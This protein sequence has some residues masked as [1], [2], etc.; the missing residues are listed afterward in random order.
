MNK[1]ILTVGF[2][3]AVV[4]GSVLLTS[5]VSAFWPFDGLFK[6]G[7]V[8]AVTTEA[9]STTS[10]SNRVAVLYKGLA[11]MNATC[12]RLYGATERVGPLETTTP[13]PFIKGKVLQTT[14]PSNESS[15]S[16]EVENPVLK[17]TGSWKE[18]PS[19]IKELAAIDTTLKSRCETIKSLLVKIKKIYKG[20][21]EATPSAKV[22][23][24]KRPGIIE[25]YRDKK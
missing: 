17:D 12:E 2:L 13:T 25:I 3:S 7:E 9:R 23:P 1:K 11:E 19:S 15:V 14:R 4:A 18:D 8:K 10:R 21:P 20:S 16:L 24:A 22:T 5:S 6:K